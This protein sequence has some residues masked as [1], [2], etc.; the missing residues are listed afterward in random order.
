MGL[1]V[2]IAAGGTAAADLSNGDQVEVHEHI[3]RPTTYRLRYSLNIDNN[4]FTLLADSR[5][6]AGADLSISV[7][8]GILPQVL[9]KGQV[10]GQR[11]HFHHGVSDSWLEVIG[12]DQT[13]EMDRTMR[14]KVWPAQA[15]SDSISAILAGYSLIADV[16][17]LSTTT[18]EETHLLVQD[19]SDLRFVRRLAR[20]YGCWFWVTTTPAGIATAHFKRPPLDG[21]PAITLKING[22]TPNVA[23]LDMDWDVER[24]N[25]AIA[26]QLGLR[27]KKV[28]DGHVDRSPLKTLGTTPLADIAARREV[29]IVAPVDVVGDLTGRAEGA[30]IDADWFVR[31]RGHTSVR[32]LGAVLRAHTLVAVEGLGS[33]H[34]GTYVVASVRHVIDAAAHAMDFELVRNGW[35]N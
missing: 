34:S 35:G 8:D 20:R 16:P 29:Q 28:M 32:A 15:I 5:L 19:D 17:A 9:V 11:A 26:S 23:A 24:P 30:L 25:A 12:G 27:D 33:R 7:P 13:M 1:D 31:L 2:S 14:Q 10:Y 18:S 4:D 21:K 22:D 3:G 6:D